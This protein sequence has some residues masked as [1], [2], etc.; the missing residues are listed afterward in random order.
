MLMNSFGFLM[1]ITLY[2]E[3]KWAYFL[4]LGGMICFFLT[5]FLEKESIPLLK[6]TQTHTPSILAD[7]CHFYCCEI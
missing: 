7:L 3:K 6:H 2:D 1:E 4:P 5:L